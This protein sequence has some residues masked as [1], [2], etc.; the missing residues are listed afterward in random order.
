MLFCGQKA[1]H[2]LCILQSFRVKPKTI[3]LGNTNLPSFYILL[4][5]ETPVDTTR[6][7]VE[8]EHGNCSGVAAIRRS[9]HCIYNLETLERAPN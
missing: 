2:H 1:S 4:H 5:E 3:H 9:L 6:Q 7:R 8:Q